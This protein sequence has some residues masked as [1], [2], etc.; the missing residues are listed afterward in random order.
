MSTIVRR[1]LAVCIVFV[2]FLMA[3][4]VIAGSSVAD[5]SFDFVGG[6][7]Y[8]W[9]LLGG[10]VGLVGWCLTILIITVVIAGVI[11]LRRLT[12]E[13]S[14]GEMI[15]V[16]VMTVTIIVLAVTAGKLGFLPNFSSR[17]IS[18]TAVIAA[19]TVVAWAAGNL[20]N[21]GSIRRAKRSDEPAQ[22][23]TR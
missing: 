14:R 18:L 15:G 2:G 12:T 6:I 4:V 1:I 13:P 16:T 19:T 7:S 22:P 10:V 11:W 23:A 8:V 21:G 17:A 9:R 3:G 5:D 20:W